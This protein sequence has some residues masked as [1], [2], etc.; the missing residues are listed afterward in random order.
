MGIQLWDVP[1]IRETYDE[2]NDTEEDEESDDDEEES[3]EKD[4]MLANLNNLLTDRKATIRDLR[5]GFVFFMDIEKRDI[6][7][8][9]TL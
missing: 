5:K 3:K 6:K 2:D 7:R 9:V 8:Y 1:C 4:R